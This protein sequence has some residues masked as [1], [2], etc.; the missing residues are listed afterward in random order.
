MGEKVFD[1]FWWHTNIGGK[2]VA[3][4]AE[5]GWL[6][7]WLG[8]W[9]QVIDGSPL[10]A[11]VS[12]HWTQ[13]SFLHHHIYNLGLLL[14]LLQCRPDLSLCPFGVRSLLCY[15]L[16]RVFNLPT[17][18]FDTNAEKYPYI[19]KKIDYFWSRNWIV[20]YCLI[21]KPPNN[22]ELFFWLKWI[23]K[24]FWSQSMK[25]KRAAPQSLILIFY[26]YGTFLTQNS[27]FNGKQGNIFFYQIG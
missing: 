3:S 26:F 17:N 27:N 4:G 9:A 13:P 10:K 7:G 15:I 1:R 21:K 6:V 23:E 19:I 25:I 22:S 20:V 24:V 8:F 16:Y 5:Q 2:G 11:L 12:L 18:F 14:L